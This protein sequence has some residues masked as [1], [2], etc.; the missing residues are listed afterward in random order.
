[1]QDALPF[2]EATLTRS[3][4][5]SSLPRRMI[6]KLDNTLTVFLHALKCRSRFLGEIIVAFSCLVTYRRDTPQ[7]L[8]SLDFE[9]ALLELD[10][11]IS[12]TQDDVVGFQ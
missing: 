10:M 5:F 4:R 3:L 1:M 2:A 6:A 7:F 12:K 11:I 9:T 8:A